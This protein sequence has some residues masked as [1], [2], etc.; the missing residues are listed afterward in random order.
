M[1][2]QISLLHNFIDFSF[3]LAAYNDEQ[4]TL[5][6]MTRSGATKKPGLV[7]RTNPSEMEG[8]FKVGNFTQGKIKRRFGMGGNAFKCF[9]YIVL[10]KR[11]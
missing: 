8:I 11:T 1:R 7:F 2:Q 10:Y 6:W 3:S 4:M 5:E 9:P